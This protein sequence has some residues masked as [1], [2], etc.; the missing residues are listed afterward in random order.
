MTL[1]KY[2]SARALDL[3]LTFASYFLFVFIDENNKIIFSEKSGLFLFQIIDKISRFSFH[4][5]THIRIES[6]KM[7]TTAYNNTT[8]D[9]S[10]DAT[11][12]QV[13]AEQQVV[14][15]IFS[16]LG[17]VSI[18]CSILLF[19][20][21]IRLSE[22]RQQHPLNQTIIY[23]LIAAFLV[24]SIDI[25]LILTYLQQYYFIQ[26][27]TNPISFCMFWYIYDCG[28][29]SLS[30]WLMA[31]FSLERYLSIFFK[32]IIMKNSIRRFIMYYLSAMI[33]ISF[34]FGWLTYFV[35]LYPCQQV[36]FEFTVMSCNLPCFLIDGSLALQN[37]NM[38]ILNL[39]PSF[40]A[41]LFTILLISHVLYQKRK[42]SK[43]LIQR[44]T[45]KRTRKMFLQLLPV[46]FAF[47]AFNQPLIIVVLLGIVDPW[48]FTTPYF[49][50]N[51]L[52]YCWSILMP[53]AILSRQPAIKKRLFT[54]LR[55]ERFNQ[56]APISTTAG[57]IKTRNH[58]VIQKPSA[59][60]AE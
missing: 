40:L 33:I 6:F 30:L 4:L 50:A 10:T 31:L 51:N 29:Y 20:Y 36:Y 41:V 57:S 12:V 43:R 42:I 37:G 59:I 15:Y 56:T 45:W 48:F 26:F 18:P 21:F 2:N 46:T 39:V 7:S 9:I 38:I 34:I 52:T 11:S 53:F 60:T 58:P 44:D 16:I 49:Y 55:L 1:D 5:L 25:P 19:Y 28:L 32:Q 27:L 47:L 13:P 17:M 22:L 23:L 14:F 3:W 35:V 54:I 24:T 8:I